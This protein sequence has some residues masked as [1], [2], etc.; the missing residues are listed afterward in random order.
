L[1]VPRR[2]NNKIA[3]RCYQLLAIQ[4]QLSRMPVKRGQQ[5]TVTKTNYYLLKE[6]YLERFMDRQ[7]TKQLQAII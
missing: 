3:T 2:P 7:G 6:N 4:D 1:R 5:L